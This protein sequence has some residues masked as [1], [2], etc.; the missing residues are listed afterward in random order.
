[1]LVH[2]GDVLGQPQIG[3][4]VGLVLDQ[5]QQVE[6]GQQRRRKLNVL[7]DGL[8]GVVAPVCRVGR[9][10]DGAAGIQ[11][12]HDASLGDKGRR[13][14]DYSL[15]LFLKWSASLHTAYHVYGA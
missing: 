11:R 12:S 9:S 2:V 6:T 8:A 4:R 13:A 5:P 14:C 1:M 15:W 10:Q 7:L 3:I